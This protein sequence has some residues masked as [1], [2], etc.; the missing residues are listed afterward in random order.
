MGLKLSHH[1]PV[2]RMVHFGWRVR[3]CLLVNLCSTPHLWQ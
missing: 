2:L 3:L 1:I